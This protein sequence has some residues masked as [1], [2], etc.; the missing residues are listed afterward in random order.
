MTGING[1]DQMLDVVEKLIAER[2]RYKAERDDLL[3][4]I[5]TLHEGEYKLFHPNGRDKVLEEQIAAALNKIKE[6]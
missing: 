1:I 5:E 2:D 4:I 3:D 6:G